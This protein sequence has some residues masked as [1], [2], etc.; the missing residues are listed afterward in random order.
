MVRGDARVRGEVKGK[1]ANALDS[2]YPSHYLGTWC[3]QHYY[4][5]CAHLGFQQS[6]E[7]MSPGPFNPTRPF[8]PKTN[9]DFCACA[10][11]FQLVSI[12]LLSRSFKLLI[13]IGIGKGTG[14]PGQLSRYSDLLQA[15]RSGDR[16]PVVA[17]FS[18][19][20]KKVHGSHPASCTMHTGSFSGRKAAGAWRWTPT[21]SSTEVIERESV[22]FFPP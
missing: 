15:G 11:T 2:Q 12:P 6:T 8:R 7:L 9:S 3:N 21:P 10:I 14:V 19:P 13:A 1:L 4:R 22:Y 20:V 16:I 18:A 5:W 17:S